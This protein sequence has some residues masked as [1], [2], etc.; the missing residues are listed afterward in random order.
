MLVRRVFVGSVGRIRT[1]P[2]GRNQIRGESALARRAYPNNS[3]VSGPDVWIKIAQ[4]E[5]P[6]EGIC[7]QCRLYL[8]TLLLTQKEKELSSS[9]SS[10][11][12]PSM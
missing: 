11:H 5:I 3:G 6:V 2:N 4:K 8:D 12:N 1:I 10:S 7:P 9:L